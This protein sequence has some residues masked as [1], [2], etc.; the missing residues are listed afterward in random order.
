MKKQM[1]GLSPKEMAKKALEML[2][3]TLPM[4]L[5]K[6]KAMEDCQ[7]MCKRDGGKDEEYWDRVMFEIYA[8][9]RDFN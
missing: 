3:A 8:Y 6:L 4:P 7:E 5:A 2:S 1:K 9:G